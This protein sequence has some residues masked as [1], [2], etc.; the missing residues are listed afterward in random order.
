M[1][2]LVITS[3][4]LERNMDE[5][6]GVRDLLIV[7]LEAHGGDD[8]LNEDGDV[9]DQE[10]DEE[11]EGALGVM[12]SR[13]ESSDVIVD[14]ID[15]KDVIQIIKGSK[16]TLED[17]KEL[18][19]VERIRNTLRRNGLSLKEPSK[20]SSLKVLTSTSFFLILSRL[21]KFKN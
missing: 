3:H 1:S 17:I 16:D 9:E 4:K 10:S 5:E 6:V 15:L 21:F 12:E 7:N 11:R 2:N 14:A 20:T 19:R 13:V 8:D 18:L